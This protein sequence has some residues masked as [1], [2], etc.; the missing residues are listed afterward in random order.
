MA[1]GID[2]S[3]YQGKVDFNKLKSYCNF[4]IIRA[5][6]TGYGDG[7]QHGDPYF[8]VNMAGAKAAGIPWGC[9][10]FSQAI[11]EAE[12]RAEAK[13][14]LSLIKEQY[15]EYPIYID[16]ESSGAPGFSGRADYLTK[17]QRTAVV[18]A[19]CDE[20]ESAGYFAG[21]YC[22]ESWYHNNIDGKSL[23]SRYTAWIAKWSAKEP[24]C[25]YA[26]WQYS[27]SGS[28]PGINGRVDL[29]KTSVN[30]PTIIKTKGLNGWPTED[31]Q[32]DYI[33]IHATGSDMKKLLEICKLYKLDYV[34]TEK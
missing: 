33:K 12:A 15:P 18:K 24:N 27:N 14:V 6:Y 30:F 25:T 17:E 7:K 34:R 22:S 16:T 5:G 10:W 3:K 20:I 23:S 19:F 9:Y 29:N 4:V 26:M 32:G 1:V 28:I 2:I 11:N 31:K 8:L 13:H 21:F